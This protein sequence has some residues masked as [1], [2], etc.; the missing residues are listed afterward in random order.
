MKRKY[1]LLGLLAL[2]G[3][4]YAMSENLGLSP[5]LINVQNRELISLNGAWQTIVDPF[6]NGFYNY[7]LEEAD[8]GYFKDVDYSGD[9]SFLQEYDFNSANELYVPGDWNTQRP[10]LYY[11]EGTVW[12]RKHFDYTKKSNKRVFLYFGAVNYEAIVY[13]NGE[14][15][16]RHIGGFT[17]F[18]I[19]VTNSI[20]QGVN[21]LVVKADNKRKPEAVPTVNADWWNF[22]G[23]TRHAYLVETPEVFVRDYHIQLDKTNPKEIAGWVQLD[24][25]NSQQQVKVTIPELKLTQSVTTNEKGFAELRIP[26]KKLTY[27]NP[28]DPKLYEVNLTLNEQ[29]LSDNIGF[30]IIATQGTDVLLNG[31]KIFLRGICIHEETAGNSARA[32]T[33]ADAI[34]LLTWAKELGCNFVRLAHYPHNENM[35]R[36]AER[37]GLMVWSEIPVYWTIYWSN[38]ATYQNAEAQLADMITRDR[39]RANVI[40]WSVANET[41]LSDAR[42]EFLKKLINKTREMDPTRLVSAAMEKEELS[43]GLMTV[44][45]PLSEYLDL[46]SFNQYIG[47]YDGTWEKC[48]RVNWQFSSNKP[49]VITEFGGGALYGNSGDVHQYFTEEYQE[50]LFVR[51]V[52]MFKRIPGLAGTTPWILKDFRSPR[53]HIPL[54]QGEFNRKGLISDKGEKKKAFFVMQKWYDEIKANETKKN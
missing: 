28:E 21:S 44:H 34:T 40:I 17:P 1:G 30:R 43:P 10:Q 45:D 32:T 3:L 53:R 6:E 23:I 26:V 27:W 18:N 51:T 36:T 41:P 8:K 42:L 16:G 29:T 24:G 48:D 22:G 20:K 15:I 39:N 5:Q 19:E 38:P 47:W 25:V 37:M 49:V 31:K 2:C 7:R 54:I 33:E 50:E 14:K 4:S 13:L 9:R 35:I 11:Y 52:N 46:I 12:Y